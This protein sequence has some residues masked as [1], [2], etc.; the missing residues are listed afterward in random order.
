[1]AG[2]AC[3]RALVGEGKRVLV[4]DKG[5]G[6]GGRVATRRVSIGADEI[7]FDHG[8]QYVPTSDTAFQ[9]VLEGAGLQV[10]QGCGDGPMHVGVPSMSALPRA[11]AKGLE[12]V[13]SAEVTGLDPLPTGWRVI[14]SFGALEA[15]RMVMTL[16][17]PQ[18]AGLLGASHPLSRAVVDVRMAPSLTLMVAFP[19]GSPRPFVSRLDPDHPLVWIAQDSSKPGRTDACVTWVAQASEAFSTAHLEDAPDAIAA[20]MLPHLCDV[21]GADPETAL[22]VAAHRW[23]YAQTAQALGQ[24]FLRSDDGRLY[25]GGDWCLGARVEHA[26]ASGRAI[27]ADISGGRNVG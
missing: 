3:A 18:V 4:L 2:I 13:Q 17:A 1:M 16:P 11:L 19:P 15:E 21:I 6:I 8:A 27:A 10:W 25:L 5:R 20:R 26:W 22:H 23:R 7:S 14:G 24:P 9:A 12:V